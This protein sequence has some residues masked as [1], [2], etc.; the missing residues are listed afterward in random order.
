MSEQMSQ[1]LII[2]ICNHGF[3][4]EA[5]KEA[6]KQSKG[7]TILHGKSSLSTEK[8]KFLELNYILKRFSINS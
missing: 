8:S 7:G 2:Y 4:Y 1:S 3:A 5:M 6:E